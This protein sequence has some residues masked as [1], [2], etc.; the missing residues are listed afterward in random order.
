MWKVFGF[1]SRW[2]WLKVVVTFLVADV[3]TEILWNVWNLWSGQS[4]EWGRISA[5]II[6][7]TLATGTYGTLKIMESKRSTNVTTPAMTP[8]LEDITAPPP[9]PRLPE[10]RYPLES[11]SPRTPEQLVAEIN[12]L[13]TIRAS[14]LVK[15]HMGML[16]PVTGTVINV[17]PGPLP[18]RKIVVHMDRGQNGINL[19]LEFDPKR[20]RQ[21]LASADTG[22][23]ISAIGKISQIENVLGTY[24]TLAEC[25]LLYQ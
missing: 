1:S 6:G 4:I 13:T 23:R 24:V 19:F 2:Q 10:N 11:I 7:A 15:A 9:Q 5:V 17:A 20:W 3:A 18:S 14:E 16:L 12:G 21:R 25:E 8:N 22:D